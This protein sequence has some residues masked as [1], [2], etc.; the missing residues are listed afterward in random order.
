MFIL[1]SS[2]QVVAAEAAHHIIFEFLSLPPARK[3]AVGLQI[4]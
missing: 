3:T 2:L 4:L 1:Y